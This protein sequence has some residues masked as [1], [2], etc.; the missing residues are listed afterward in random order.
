M[1]M[2]QKMRVPRPRGDGPITGDDDTI[3]PECSPPA[4]GWTAFESREH[5][6]ARVF[7]ARAGMDRRAV[8]A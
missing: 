6:E 3:T 1:D 4:R 7:P 8:H 2:T 5:R